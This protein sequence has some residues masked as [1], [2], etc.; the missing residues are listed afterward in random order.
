MSVNQGDEGKDLEI[1][2]EKKS[3]DKQDIEDEEKEK[4]MEE[5]EIRGGEVEKRKKALEEAAA[6]GQ[7]KKRIPTG[8]IKIPGFLKSSRSR[9]KNK[10][11][12]IEGEEENDLIEPT[13]TSE[14]LGED[15]RQPKTDLDKKLPL[16]GK[17][18][19]INVPF[20][21]RKK[22]QDDG[23]EP[24]ANGCG[25]GNGEPDEN[26]RKPKLINAIKLPLASLVPKKHKTPKDGDHG[27]SGGPQAGLASMETLDD[28][29]C[30][31]KH[32][33]GME[34]VRL[35]NV[36]LD[37]EKAALEDEAESK[38]ASRDWKQYWKMVKEHKIAVG[39][40]GTI[41]VVLLILIIAIASGANSHS[42]PPSPVHGRFI[43]AQTSC[44]LIEG[45]LEDG[46]HVFRGIPY[47]LPPV[48]HLRFAPPQTFTLNDCWNGTLKVHNST[49]S[50]WQMFV[51]GSLDGDEN[52]LTLDVYSPEVRYESPF[53]VVVL[54]GS[55]SLL[56]G[57]P[58]RL[59]PSAKVA[60]DNE[61]VFVQPHFRMGP[62]GFLAAR[63]LSDAVYPRTSG[64]YG[65]ADIV[66]A[67]LWVQ[68]NIVHFG[69]DP[70][71]VTVLGYR[72]GATLVTALTAVHKPERLFSRAWISSG[73]TVFP[74]ISLIDSEN[75]S[76]SYLSD[77]PCTGNTSATVNCL[78]E[79]DVEELLDNIP[80]NWRGQDKGNLPKE[81]VT[82]YQWLV[83]DGIN[84]R[85][86]PLEKWTS[87]NLSVQVILGTTAHS[88]ISHDWKEF[89]SAW[90]TDRIKIEI[91][92]SQIGVEG[93]TDKAIALYGNNLQGL[94]A[95]TSEI[96]TICP[97]IK[98]QKSIPYSKFYL[99]NQPTDSSGM[100]YGGFDVDAILGTKLNESL[101]PNVKKFAT[102]IRKL[103]YKY[104][105]SGEQ[106]PYRMTSIGQNITQ[107]NERNIETRCN[108]WKDAGFDKFARIE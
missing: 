73:S 63:P 43:T 15:D 99:V 55:E 31:F 10:E 57:W 35:D 46:G 53:P 97:L 84:I 67:L 13:G 21:K 16:I 50:C 32:D 107:L 76:D 92:K 14:R 52:C 93:L 6:Q 75:Q 79:I 3:E 101:D 69:G 5:K 24:S 104:V 45:L 62:L 38:W 25:T 54:I 9:D 78:R 12:E 2:Q 39:A 65:L 1:N 87:G 42:P 44:G 64:N 30:S 40:I 90:T 83:Q 77:L 27:V 86:H 80:D 91:N 95:I 106:L 33:D 61:V 98:L 71:A 4:M 85:Q 96:S 48:G 81:Q 102:I 58:G 74:N 100:S 36:E 47:A 103:F 26:Q 8:G 82:G 7:D 29:N 66:Q 105:H 34:N 23:E 22:M 108:L 41:L 70:K 11:G 94:A 56:G 60:V 18:N 51:N 72:A 19:N 59:Y 20:L 88:E 68:L 28:S 49:P 17:L 89:R 37:P